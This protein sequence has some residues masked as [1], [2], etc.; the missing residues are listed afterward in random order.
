ML[1]KKSAG[2]STRPFL[3][4]SSMSSHKVCTAKQYAIAVASVRLTHCCVSD[5]R[6]RKA[7]GTTKPEHQLQSC[8]RGLCWVWW[9]TLRSSR[10]AYGWLEKTLQGT[11]WTAPSRCVRI[12]LNLTH[13]ALKAYF[14]FNV[15]HRKQILTACT[16]AAASMIL[17]ISC[18][19]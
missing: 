19:S 2:L 15:L 8:W 12:S 6:S 14:V 9:P 5:A 7:L 17:A 11:S 18:L 3:Y 13:C 10:T 4:C 1:A 16:T